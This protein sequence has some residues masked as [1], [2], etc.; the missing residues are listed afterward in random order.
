ML[1]TD[2]SLIS[3]PCRPLSRSCVC[4]CEAQSRRGPRERKRQ[5]DGVIVDQAHTLYDAR[6]ETLIG[7][8]VAGVGSCRRRQFMGCRLAAAPPMPPAD[9]G[10]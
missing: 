6:L 3:R 1:C 2:R 5:D 7:T 9:C 8:Y 10:P 4:P